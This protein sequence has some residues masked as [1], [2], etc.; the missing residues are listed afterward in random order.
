MENS[1]E[2]GKAD[3][4]SQNLIDVLSILDRA[5]LLDQ[6][7]L[8]EEADKEWLKKRANQIL[9]NSFLADNVDELVNRWLKISY[10]SKKCVEK[11]KEK[12]IVGSR[13]FHFAESLLLNDE[14]RAILSSSNNGGLY[15]A[16]LLYVNLDD[17]KV[18]FQQL[19]HFRRVDSLI[20]PPA[21]PDFYAGT[22]REIINLPA[23][24]TD[25]GKTHE[26]LLINSINNIKDDKN[27]PLSK[28]IFRLKNKKGFKELFTDE[29]LLKAVKE[30]NQSNVS[31]LS[32]EG[33]IQRIIID[34][35]VISRRNE[36]REWKWKYEN[37]QGEIKPSVEDISIVRNAI[38]LSNYIGKDRIGLSNDE[39]INKFV[40][41]EDGEVLLGI[42]LQRLADAYW[43][44]KN[45]NE[46]K[47]RSTIND[48]SSFLKDTLK[49]PELK[50][51]IPLGTNKL[52]PS[53]G[54]FKTILWI[55]KYITK[56]K[57]R[58][59]VGNNLFLGPLP[60]NHNSRNDTKRNNVNFFGLGLKNIENLDFLDQKCVDFLIN[61]KKKDWSSV[62]DDTK[63]IF[64]T[65]FV[66]NVPLTPVQLAYIMRVDPFVVQI[67]F[68]FV[69]Y[70]LNIVVPENY[71]NYKEKF[72]YFAMPLDPIDVT[73]GQQRLFAMWLGI[74]RFNYLDTENQSI[75]LYKGLSK[76]R[77]I[78]TTIGH[79]V[80]R[81]VIEK[82]LKRQRLIAERGQRRAAAAAIMSRNM[83]HNLGSH[84]LSFLKQDFKSTKVIF[85][86]NGVL[87]PFIG[88]LE[89]ELD[90]K[91]PE[92]NNSGNIKNK[93]FYYKGTSLEIPDAEYLVGLGRFLGY[94]QER[95][96]YIATISSESIPYFSSL[97]FIDFVYD[98]FMFHLKAARHSG[99]H[100]LCKNL[101]LDNIARSEHLSSDTIDLKI[102]NFD[103]HKHEDKE[104]LKKVLK[105]LKVDFPGGISGR[106]AIFS[107]LENL[108]RNA[109]KHGD[110][111]G[112]LVLK[113][114]FD[115]IKIIKDEYND[116]YLYKISISDNSKTS[117]E[118]INNL[119]RAVD[120][121]IIDNNG[122]MIE[123]NKGLKEIKISAAW[124][125]GI[126]STEVDSDEIFPSI[127]TVEPT[128]EGGLKYI[129]HL[130]RTLDLCIVA[131]KKSEVAKELMK[132]AIDVVDPEEI[133]NGDKKQLPYR[134]VI[135]DRDSVDDIS[136]ERT[137]KLSTVRCFSL[138]LKD[139]DLDYILKISNLYKYYLE[140]KKKWTKEYKIILFDPGEDSSEIEYEEK[141]LNMGSKLQPK[142]LKNN[143]EL[144]IFKKH[145]DTKKNF[146]RFINDKSVS[147]YLEKINYLEGISGGNS[148][149]RIIRSEKKDKEWY[150]RLVESALTKV[151]IVDERLWT[152]LGDN[153]F[154]TGLKEFVDTLDLSLD[155]GKI[156]KVLKKRFHPC[157]HC[158]N[159]KISEDCKKSSECSIFIEYEK[160]IE[161]FNDY[162]ISKKELKEKLQNFILKIV[163][164]KNPFPYDVYSRKNIDIINILKE[165]RP[166]AKFSIRNLLAE[167]VGLFERKD[168]INIFIKSNHFKKPFDFLVIHQGILD[169]LY[170]E[171]IGNDKGM[172]DNY[173]Y[174]ID[175]IISHLKENFCSDYERVKLIIHSGRSLPPVMPSDSS[176]IQFSSLE[177]SLFD[178]KYTLT[179]LLYSSICV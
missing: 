33:L 101:L 20:Y 122:S 138:N 131:D 85:Q 135:I 136:I 81:D 170:D 134:F 115:P 104:K 112:R 55:K 44:K 5:M 149:S 82:D 143:D 161:D 62:Y 68:A 155:R 27:H 75:K 156:E 67:Q 121:H 11:G 3:E 144:I 113:I 70:K 147:E 176:F 76:I 80:A 22:L 90:V 19:H 84:I 98:E 21:D 43:T 166:N 71:S 179:E 153:N 9:E 28:T 34:D 15:D 48:L 46:W 63:D 66:L 127:L 83:S 61:F 94:L 12:K 96:D 160:Y 35:Y 30:L 163:P 177:S 16:Y 150:F 87:K 24:G 106:Q 142:K 1:K 58:G 111:G 38:S 79:P 37:K 50:I 152:S 36:M 157:I 91:F 130:R 151:L 158:N 73:R 108:I 13:N 137:K 29:N 172:L 132:K 10:I 174:E 60:E 31:E 17:D 145:N 54:L 162:M 139:K 49:K 40:L 41:L 59:T 165:D 128:N 173:Q 146:K 117:L 57:D 169:K 52:V 97:N 168:D 100:D 26:E 95:Q 107:M 116:N 42:Y 51:F 18:P 14:V 47:K 23:F 164:N 140:N 32:E 124:L 25:C 126:H 171:Y 159:H 125:R 53:N 45:N 120:E 64:K 72:Y 119:K 133:I 6:K 4:K 65:F 99:S 92:N 154:D 103:G 78:L 74:F 102:D 77:H 7:M 110:L 114:E 88:T 93:Y 178:C 8:P 129:F 167:E 141:I 2:I 69:E 175:R 123:T 89:N 109:A 86:K 39:Y 118:C 105:E 148:T 56:T